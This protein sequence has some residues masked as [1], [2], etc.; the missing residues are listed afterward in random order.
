MV[1]IGSFPLP[2][3]SPGGE[4]AGGNVF[5]LI[6]EFWIFGLPMVDLE[7]TNALLSAPLT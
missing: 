7:G 5:R 6:E 2:V 4:T 3:C 1:A